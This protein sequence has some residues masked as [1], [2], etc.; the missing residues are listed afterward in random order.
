MATEDTQRIKIEEELTD[1]DGGGC[2]S[3]EPFALRVLGDSMEPEFKDG[4]VIIIDPDG[5]AENGNY[6]IAEIDGDYIFRQY[7]EE[8][9]QGFLQAIN[10]GYPRQD[11]ESKSVI[12]GV[13]TQRAGARRKYHK[14][15]E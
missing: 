7:M 5:V 10:P 8:A 9:S 14:R 15:Y 4:C 1:M 3:S 11:I 12:R 6:V 13:V 2:A